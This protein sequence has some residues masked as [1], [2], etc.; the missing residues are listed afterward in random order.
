MN[1]GM[2]AGRMPAKVSVAERAIVTAGLKWAPEI[3]PSARMI[4]MS[5]AP[6]ASVFARSAMATFPPARRSP[7]MPDPTT[8]ASKSAVPRPSATSLRP[9]VG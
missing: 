8:V 4:A 3:G 7:M 6:V 2:S 1:P 5:P 9:R